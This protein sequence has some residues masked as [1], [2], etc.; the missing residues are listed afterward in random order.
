MKFYE[1]C[2]DYIIKILCKM[3]HQSFNN[4]VWLLLGKK[5]KNF[6]SITAL[7][8]KLL[9]YRKLPQKKIV[10]VDKREEEVEMRK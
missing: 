5:K 8:W 2:L 10:E 3:Y 4:M 9:K 6:T 7:H 1:H